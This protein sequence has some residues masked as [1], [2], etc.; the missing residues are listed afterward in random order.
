MITLI[1]KDELTE[2]RKHHDSTEFEN[3]FKKLEV[4]FNETQ[5][6][7]NKVERRVLHVEHCF[8]SRPE[9]QGYRG[10]AP[11]LWSVE[12]FLEPLGDT[13]SHLEPLLEPLGA[14]WSHLEPLGAIWSF[15]ELFLEPR[16]NIEFFMKL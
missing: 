11:A 6:F 16:L 12:P 10:L 7:I 3:T 9:E 15:L 13:W 8:F 1:Q 5:D 4:V 14:I 2:L